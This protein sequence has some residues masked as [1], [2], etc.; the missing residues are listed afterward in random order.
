MQCITRSRNLPPSHPCLL[1]LFFTDSPVTNITAFRPRS[2]DLELDLALQIVHS[3]LTALPEQLGYVP[4]AIPRG[5]QIHGL[6]V[7][8]LMPLAGS[9]RVRP[10]YTAEGTRGADLQTVVVKMGYDE[11]DILREVGKILASG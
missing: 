5:F 10:I 9:G 2:L 6:S 8:D 7:S 4:P 11:D 1:L 3:F